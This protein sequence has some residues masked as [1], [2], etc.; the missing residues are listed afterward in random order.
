MENDK[1]INE[2]IYSLRPLMDA[3]KE[4]M[5]SSRIYVRLDDNTVYIKTS[6]SRIIVPIIL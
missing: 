6:Y 1:E 2:L 4:A 5:D 3:Q